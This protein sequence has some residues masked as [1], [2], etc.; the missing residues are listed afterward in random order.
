MDDAAFARMCKDHGWT[1][2]DEASKQ[3][4]RQS[5]ESNEENIDPAYQTKVVGSRQ[6]GH[7]ELASELFDEIRGHINS[8]VDGRV[9]AQGK[10]WL[11]LMQIIDQRLSEHDKGMQRLSAL[12]KLVGAMNRK[13]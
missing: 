5:L 9:A 13:A 8:M 12:E 4:V 11:H 7:K 1:E 2:W 6:L 10:E 3:S